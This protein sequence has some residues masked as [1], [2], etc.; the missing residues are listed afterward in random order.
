[1][2][3]LWITRAAPFAAL[4]LGYA[5]NDPTATTDEPAGNGTQGRGGLGV[6]A[7]CNG[8][9]A[10]RVGLA[11][12]VAAH[13]CAPGHSLADGAACTI[14]GECKGG[15]CASGRCAAAGAGT[16]GAGCTTDADC[17]SG[18]RCALVGFGAQCA[19]EGKGDVGATCTSNLDCLGGLGCLQGACSPAPQGYFGAPWPG[20][21]CHDDATQVVA[22]F[23]LPRG[24]DD[25][26]F[27]RL[28]FPN[29]ARIK[30]GHPDLSGHPTPGASLLG[31]DPVDRY[32]RAIE[33]DDDGWGLYQTTFFRFS[34]EL[35]L[36]SFDGNVHLVDLTVGNTV[37]LHYV[38][39]VGGGGY[40][41]GNWLAVRGGV[42]QPFEPGHVYASWLGTGIKAKGGAPVGRS[43]DLASLLGDAPPADA[44]VAAAYPSY[45]PLRAYLA[46]NTV[47]PAT[48]LDATVFTIGH[49]RSIVEK[50]AA[51]VAAGAVPTATKWTKCAAG[52]AS[53]CPDATGDRGC[54]AA[55][56][57]FDELHALVSLPIYQDGKAPYQTPADGG[58]IALDGAGAPKVVRTEDVCLSLTVPKGPSG[59]VWPTVVFAH[60]T[61]GSFRSHVTNGIAKDFAKGVDDGVASGV[62]LHKA[63]VLGIDQ[64]EHGPRRGGSL[65]SPNDLFYDFANPR[66]ARG[67]V[68]QGA[69]DQLSLLRFV[70][71]VAF[72]DAT[73]PTGAGFSLSAGVAFWGH[74]QGATEGALALPYGGWLG[75]TLS[76]EGASLLDALLTKTSPVNLAV[77]VPFALSDAAGDG[78][79]RGG[80]NNPVLSLLQAYIDPADPLGYARLAAAA[81]PAG[82]APHHV[83]QP[84]GLG[85]TYAPSIVQQ[86]YA[87]AA[88][89]GLAAPDVSV[90]TPEPIGALTAIPTPASGNLTVAGKPV[91]ALV[92]QYAPDK[93]KDGHFVVFDRPT[94]RGDA[95]R[96]LTGALGGKVPVVGQ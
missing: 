79:L 75:A 89:L 61:G 6:G 43:P 56:P 12:D 96:F 85:D 28:P 39:S 78:T 32:L 15:L 21:S 81:P 3:T 37:A 73:S 62:L 47:D 26:D 30:D 50:L 38:Y 33:Q 58:G 34:G 55:D 52:V 84:Y 4:L 92:R 11:C 31:F 5:C 35:E 19:P 22:Y 9:S 90:T 69:A 41:C 17:M 80:R 48:V 70:P 42:G 82:G 93:G 67:N 14:S 86:T 91:T 29:D 24:K 54:T 25:G 83:F 45:A 76:G 66:A 71:T 46:K 51:S 53:P 13:T 10:C 36:G 16:T 74:S 8:D 64:V 1:M 49:T 95:E 88:G 27:Y 59:S 2:R 40:I 63:A 87:L 18:L 68:L 77:A 20:V 44:V 23:Q 60:G 65:G 94:A 72:T 7:A 57:D